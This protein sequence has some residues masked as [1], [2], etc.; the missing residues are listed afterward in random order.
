MSQAHIKIEN[1]VKKFGEFTALDNVNLEVKEGEFFCFLGPSGCGKTTL[2]RAVAGLDMQTS[3][4][5]IM[6]GKDVSHTPPAK[7]DFG[8]VFQSYALFPNMKVVDNIAYGM[9]GKGFSRQEIKDKV[10]SLLNM[11][12]L[13]EH[14]QKYP[15]QL[16]GGQQQ[17]VALTRALATSPSLLLLDEPLSALDAK[18]R[19]HLRKEIKEL[20]RDLGVTTI[21]VTH[22]QEEALA[23]S[24]RIVILRDGLVE[25]TGTPQ[26]IYSRPANAFVADFIGEMNFLDGVVVGENSIKVGEYILNADTQGFAENLS[27]VL[28][29]RPEDVHVS[30]T[31]DKG[32]GNNQVEMRVQHIEYLG[33]LLRTS[34][35]C[36]KAEPDNL[37]V[38]ADIPM[39]LV[40]SVSL[41]TGTQ[42]NVNLPCEQIRVYPK[43][44]NG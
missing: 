34:L 9:K 42:L 32:E 8:I 35:K 22:D 1:L 37:E 14:A 6:K 44:S 26:E 43:V 16:S 39:N 13:S 31:T 15:A 10:E 11:V 21:M 27:V 40:R 12:G 5:V 18:V 25:Q 28:A 23:M 38:R 7:R 17:R 29:I 36:E 41:D 30:E 2:L 4:R 33:S 24:D 19:N 20:Q 3:G